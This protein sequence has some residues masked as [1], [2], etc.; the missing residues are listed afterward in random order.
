MYNDKV[1]SNGTSLESDTRP[2]TFLVFNQGGTKQTFVPG[3]SWVAFVF[4][5][6]SYV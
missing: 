5:C 4:C 3:S 1:A 2:S 6:S